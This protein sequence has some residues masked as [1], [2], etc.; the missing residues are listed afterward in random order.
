MKKA[1]SY[2]VSG[3]EGQD[4]GDRIVK[5]MRP[6]FIGFIPLSHVNKLYKSRHGNNAEVAPEGFNAKADVGQSPPT[7]NVPA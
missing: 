7:A 4:H 2:Y 5:T 3:R 6:T 1:L